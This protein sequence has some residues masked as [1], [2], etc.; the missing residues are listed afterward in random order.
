VAAQLRPEA[1]VGK[2][3]L[4]EGAE[5]RLEVADVVAALGATQPHAVG[6]P[7]RPHQRADRVG[8]L[9]LVALAGLGA[10]RAANT[11]GAST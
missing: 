11:E 3:K 4:D 7:T 10:A 1:R 8:E 2:R 5:V 9:D 6:P